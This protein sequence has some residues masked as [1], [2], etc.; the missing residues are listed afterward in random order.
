M[1]LLPIY[2]TLILP[3]TRVYF[4]TEDFKVVTNHEPT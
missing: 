1:I 4:Q 2:N 3:N